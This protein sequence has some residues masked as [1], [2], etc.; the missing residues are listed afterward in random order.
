MDIN[1]KYTITPQYLPKPSKRRSGLKINKVRFLVAHDTGNPGSTA[2]QNVKYYTNSA[3]TQSASAHLFVDD[4]QILE[5]VPA[6][7]ADPEKAWH[8]LYN[9]PKDNQ[10]YGV[11]ANDAAIGVEYCYG[12]NIDADKAYDKY[13]WLMAK[14]CITFDLDPTKDIVGHYF[15]DPARKTDPI[16][17]LAASRRSYEQFLRDVAADVALFKGGVSASVPTEPF[18]QQAKVLVKLNARSEPNTRSGVTEVLPSGTT[19]SIVERTQVGELI[20]NNSLW[21]KD[22]N[23]R[24]FWSGGLTFA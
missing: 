2:A 16:T 3:Q 14:L 12:G 5:C 6:L 18:V 21:Y 7:T 4:K 20:N 1:N 23:G 13:V 9:V 22:A 15:L 17:G 11:N 8:V 10:L 24:W 19:V